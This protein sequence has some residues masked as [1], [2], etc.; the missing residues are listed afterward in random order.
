MSI[1]F[2]F[3]IF[4]IIKKCTF[5]ASYKGLKKNPKMIYCSNVILNQTGYF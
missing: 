3:V 4:L 2:I 1:P 5:L